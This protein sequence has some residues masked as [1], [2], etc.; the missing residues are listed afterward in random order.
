[1]SLSGYLFAKLLDGKRLRYLAFLWNRALRLL[2]LMLCV[3]LVIAMQQAMRDG[4]PWL[5]L[6]TAIR[7]LVLPVWPNG[8]WSVTVE[9]HFYVLLPILLALARSWPLA[10]ILVVLAFSL[11]RLGLWFH[12][13]EVQTL[14]YWTIVGG[15]DQFALGIF[16][17]NARRLIIGRNILAGAVIVSLF[18]FVYGF[19]AMG[20]F[21]TAP[22]YPSP[23][24]IWIIYP[25][26]TGAAFGFLIAW[27]DSSFEF[28]D[29]GLSRL[30]ARIGAC[31]YSI[32]LLH[33]FFYGRASAFIDHH[34]VKLDRPE[35][36][37]PFALMAFLAF[38]PVAYLSYILVERP[39][40][41]FRMRYLEERA[42]V[43][44]DRG[45]PTRPSP[46]I[47]QPSPRTPPESG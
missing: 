25:T 5:L 32:Y 31:S 29:R 10:P 28:K 30:V 6:G 19:D 23:S 42:P 11:L 1:M 46:S 20:G 17:Y 12:R 27:Y 37:F 8:G 33:P 4:E 26:V 3:F 15:I 39:P 47:G 13:G 2:P 22:S 40:L 45:L 9:L 44:V 36:V 43:A 38:V 34:I 7:G 14:A 18:L 16:A 35:L 41:R 21:Y 24:F